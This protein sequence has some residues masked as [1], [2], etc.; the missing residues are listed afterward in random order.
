MLCTV[1]ALRLHV[2]PAVAGCDTIGLVC[3][4]DIFSKAD[5]EQNSCCFAGVAQTDIFPKSDKGKLGAGVL[6]AGAV[7]VG[8]SPGGG[9]QSVLKVATDS[10]LT[11]WPSALPSFKINS[12]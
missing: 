10:S 8:Q 9:A 4:Y 7:A 3:R 5:C 1:I 11:G 2:H 6:A 12:F